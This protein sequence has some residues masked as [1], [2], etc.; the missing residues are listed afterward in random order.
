[1]PKMIPQNTI[2]LRR[3]EGADSKEVSVPPGEPFMFTAKEV[4]QIT[5]GDPKALRKPINESGDDEPAG[6]GGPAVDGDD[7]DEG[8]KEATSDKPAAKKPAGKKPAADDDDL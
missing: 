4:E 1:M 2:I 3:G 7:A 8:K 5:A 6:K